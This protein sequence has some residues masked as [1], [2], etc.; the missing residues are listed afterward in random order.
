MKGCIRAGTWT[1]VMLVLLAASGCAT[2]ADLTTMNQELTARLDALQASV[3][4]HAG[5]LRTELTPMRGLLEEARSTG[6]QMQ[7]LHKDVAAIGAC[8]EQIPQ[9]LSSL[10]ANVRAMRRSMMD[11]L[12]SEEA[13]LRERLKALQEIGRHLEPDSSGSTPSGKPEK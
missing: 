6:K 13:A 1:G 3:D 2:K 5:D 7:D 9:Q 10:G 4:K 8:F 11:S 12:K